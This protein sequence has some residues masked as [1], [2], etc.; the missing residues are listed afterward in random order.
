VN[1]VISVSGIAV[2]RVINAVLSRPIE[3]RLRVPV[4]SDLLGAAK[5]SRHAGRR[6]GRRGE[7][8]DYA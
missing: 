3:H 7:E 6:F 5:D 1:P 8:R 4:R 2:R